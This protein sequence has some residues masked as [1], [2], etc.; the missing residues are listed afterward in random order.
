MKI[1]TVLPFLLLPLNIFAQSQPNQIMF[2][3]IHKGKVIGTLNAHRYIQNG[4]NLYTVH[5][6]ITQKVLHIKECL[7]DL[8]VRYNNG[9]L[10]SSDYKLHINGK[11]D[12]SA[13]TVQKDNV[14]YG[15]KNGN[16]EVALKHPISF[17]SAL[18]YF[19]EPQG[20]R[21]MFSESKLIS[22]KLK[23]HPQKQHVYVLDKNKGEYYYENGQLQKIIYDELVKIELIRR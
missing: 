21:N 15:T 20:V 6:T 14:L 5:T 9:Q 2:D 16:K 13:T 12:R 8:K 22:R 4:E 7:Y 10:I 3:L 17:S 11:L 23:R 18:F 19:L 1:P